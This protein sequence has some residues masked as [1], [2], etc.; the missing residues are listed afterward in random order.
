MFGG[1]KKALLRMARAVLEN[2]LSQLMQQF[3]VVEEMALSPMR[4]IIE[5]V[6]G[7]V[8]VGNGANA[9]VEEVSSL[10]IPG[11]GQVNE[12]ITFVHTN[13]GRARDILD[14]A[15]QQVQTIVNGVSDTFQAVY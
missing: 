12:Q 2:V 5:Q 10:M 14:A 9:F 3:N 15:D 11:V 4:M 6:V 13:L 7:G 1:I 8:W